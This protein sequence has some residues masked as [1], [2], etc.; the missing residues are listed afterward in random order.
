MTKFNNTELSREL[1]G[2]QEIIAAQ[3][4][5][6]QEF[7]GEINSLK[8]QLIALSEFERQIRVIANLDHPEARRGLFGIGG[9]AP[10]DLDPKFDLR[11]KHNAL[12]REMHEQTGQLEQAGA[13]QEKN[14]ESLM[15]ELDAQKNLLKCTPA[16]QPAEGV[17]TS[18]FGER[19]S[20]FTGMAE[21]HS[22]LD[23]AAPSGTPVIAPA[24]GRVTFADTKG[25]FGK[26]MVISHGF[27]LVT[28]YAHLDDFVKNVGDTVK[29]GE[30]IAVMGNT[31]RSTGPHLH[32]EVHLNSMPV[33]PSDY[34]LN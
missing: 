5:Q 33:D 8:S 11:K 22:G 24:D 17:L 30:K 19:E 32:Y 10:E 7:A 2:Q 16:I 1:S 13:V 23:I 9:S 29:R 28:R 25:S 18:V 14:F 34:I 20:P 27:G 3:R 21:F 4:K 6:I 26:M 12:I 31:G 15:K